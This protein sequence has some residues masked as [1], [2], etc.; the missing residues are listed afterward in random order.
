MTDLVKRNRFLHP[1]VE[2]QA[3]AAMAKVRRVLTVVNALI[4]QI[5]SNVPTAVRV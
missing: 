5:D 2:A 1:Q 4:A 3:I